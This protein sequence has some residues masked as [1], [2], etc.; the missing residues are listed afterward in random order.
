MPDGLAFSEVM[1]QIY[2]AR[3][4][5]CGQTPN[6]LA[7]SSDLYDRIEREANEWCWPVK[8][9]GSLHDFKIAGV[10]IVRAEMDA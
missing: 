10:R 8:P 2:E 9:A 4:T 7:V 3:R 1:R 6:T 5:L